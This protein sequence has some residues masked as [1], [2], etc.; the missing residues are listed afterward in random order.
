MTTKPR[1]FDPT[2]MALT[3]PSLGA[4]DCV[5][6]IEGF[7]DLHIDHAEFHSPGDVTVHGAYLSG[8]RNKVRIFREEDGVTWRDSEQRIVFVF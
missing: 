6:D 4:C 1:P 3:S 2:T 8:G 5:L 7:E